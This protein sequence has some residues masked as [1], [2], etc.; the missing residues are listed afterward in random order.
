MIKENN[1]AAILSELKYIKLAAWE[2]TPKEFEA[3]VRIWTKHLQNVYLTPRMVETGL[4]FAAKEA[5]DKMPSVGTFSKW[6]R[7]IPETDDLRRSYRHARKRI[8]GLEGWA[9]PVIYHAALTELGAQRF[10][11]LEEKELMKEWGK[12]IES[13]KDKWF[14]G[15]L[16]EIPKPETL[17][18]QQRAEISEEQR[19]E[20]IDRLRGM[21]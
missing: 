13:A 2:P 17:I 19:Q 1:V 8:N 4:S 16:P 15:E 21:I 7:Y 5:W 10:L 3:A 12:A 20:N 18:E 6:C 9:H 11:N 14:A